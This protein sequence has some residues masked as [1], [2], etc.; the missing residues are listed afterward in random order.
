MVT[1]L[2]AGNLWMT[3]VTLQGDGQPGRSDATRGIHVKDFNSKVYA[4]SA[5]PRLPSSPCPCC[6]SSALCTSTPTSLVLPVR[7]TLHGS[8]SYLSHE[9]NCM[10]PMRAHSMFARVESVCVR[11]DCVYASLGGRLTSVMQIS[12]GTAHFR[13]STF[14][15]L[16]PRGRKTGAITLDDR[17]E[18]AVDQCIFDP[19]NG[20]SY[21]IG[22]YKS[23][24]VCRQLTPHT[25]HPMVVYVFAQV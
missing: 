10:G 25:L 16:K 9:A 12:I 3:D 15:Q 8:L 22:L 23:T 20:G 18:L 6:S 21:V 11:A 13:N 5:L 7:R 4:E 14:Q 1:I 24:K 19:N 2:E 17:A